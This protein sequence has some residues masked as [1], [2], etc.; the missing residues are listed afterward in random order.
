MKFTLI[1]PLAALLLGAACTQTQP[2][3]GQRVDVDFISGGF[4][5]NSGSAVYVFAK[6]FNYQ[7]KVA[8]CGAWAATQGSGRSN[9]Y[10][11]QVL[12]AGSIALDGTLLVN[13]LG[14]FPEHPDPKAIGGRQAA[15]VATDR[16][17]LPEYDDKKP[18][19]RFPPMSFS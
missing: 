8:V 5:W 4:Q 10:N 16:P 1:G 13:G 7:G 3:P 14:F 6:T 11:E 17:W 9:L 2:I 15:C 19:I 12:G 18:N